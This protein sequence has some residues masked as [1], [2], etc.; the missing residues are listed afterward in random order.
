MTVNKRMPAEWERHERTI[1]Q[2][3]VKKSMIHPDN[4]LEFCIGYKE[5]I[6][7]ILKFEDVTLAVNQS[8]LESAERHLGNKVDYA[9]IEHNDAWARDSVPT[10]IYEES[11]KRQGINWKFNAWGG[12][13]APWDLDDA[14]GSKILEHLKIDEIRSFLVLEGGSIHSDG[15]GTLMTTEEC[16]LNKNRNPGKTKEEIENALSDQ[17]GATKFIWLEKGLFGD[18]TDGH[19]DNIACFSKPGVVLIQTCDDPNDP[20]YDISRKSLEVL[21]NST[22]ASGNKIKVIQ[23]PQPPYREYRGKRLTLSYINFYLV[24]GGLILPI[25]GEDASDFDIRAQNILQEAFPDRK[26]VTV[27]GIPLVREGGNVHCITQQIPSKILQGG[28]E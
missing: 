6:E 11:K 5:I 3:P 14:L 4:Y 8:D 20:N 17:L 21:E 27:D 24:N 18:E 23:I 7:S 15:I 28:K 2:W 1:I 25:F 22:D 13:Y 12:K 19:I 10:V 9:V 26:I 16:L